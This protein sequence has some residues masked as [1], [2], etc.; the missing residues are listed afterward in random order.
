MGWQL[1]VLEGVAATASEIGSG[2][3]NVLSST[4]LSNF[5]VDNATLEALKQISGTEI[6]PLVNDL[7]E[8]IGYVGRAAASSNGSTALSTTWMTITRDAQVVTQELIDAAI[9]LVEGGTTADL[10]VGQ[11]ITKAGLA[12]GA[13]V[14]GAAGTGVGTTALATVA[15]PAIAVALGVGAGVALYELAPEFW[16]NVSERLTSAGKMI[17]GKVISWFKTDGTEYYDEETIDIIRQALIQEGILGANFDTT[18]P[19]SSGSI[20]SD[21]LDANIALDNIINMTSRSANSWQG[22]DGWSSTKVRFINEHT[23]DLFNTGL[24]TLSSNGYTKAFGGIVSLTGGTYSQFTIELCVAK[25]SPITGR[26]TIGSTNQYGYKDYNIS[27]LINA[28]KMV[29]RCDCSGNGSISATI[30]AITAA[31]IT[32]GISYISNY[33]KGTTGFG[34]WY[35]NAEQTGFPEQEL[36]E[37]DNTGT[38]VS[39]IPTSVTDPIHNPTQ[40]PNQNPT[41]LYDPTP[42]VEPGPEDNPNP[43]IDPDPQPDPETDPA[44]D[45]HPTSPTAP[46]D[47]TD[48]NPPGDNDDDSD[49]EVPPVVIPMAASALSKVFNPTQAETD[50]LGQY[51][52]SSTNI[53]DIL[54]LFQNPIDGIIGF[55]KLYA[56]PITGSHAN[57]KLGYLDSGVSAAVV[58][59]QIVTV[60]CGSINI[61][62]D[63]ANATDYPPYTTMQIYLPFIGIEPLNAYDLVGSQLAVRYRVDCY[64]GAC[65]AQLKV[66]R[67]N[68][69]S[70]LYEFSGNC[71]QQIPLTSGNYLQLAGNIIS[72]AITGGVH[73]GMVGAAI[74]AGSSLIHSNV[75]VGRSGN[76]SAN[77]G[78]L[79]CRV[80]YVIITR[81]VSADAAN[82]RDFYGYPANKT[83]YLKNCS[84]YTR[85]KDIILHTS[86]TQAERNEIEQLL[87]TGIII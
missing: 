51:L 15:G 75:E 60:D 30:G 50:A 25:S 45:P 48:P 69:S 7:G 71:A 28:A 9:P 27:Q 6:A 37:D 29:I 43:D 53:E 72:G 46:Q 17:G 14:G 83:V 36:E 56:T 79:G 57:I 77:A 18:M 12:A 3:Y 85:V 87:K 21:I 86:A 19:E 81:A 10:Q 13:G 35:L 80:P 39:P 32:E 66:T 64:T 59:Q 84:G 82:Y 33:V 1:E 16:T 41:D 34:K 74:G 49:P 20:T 42:T 24:S 78:I 65:I 22:E 23:G 47:P 31:T 26:F 40:N 68:L 61:P 5:L 62:G 54:K 76:L 44:P 73:G 52:W 2:V 67:D 8:T 70:V 58:T 11:E 63:K 38:T 4:P 55:M